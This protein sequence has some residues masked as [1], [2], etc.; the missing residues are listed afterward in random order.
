MMM[1]KILLF[2]ITQSFVRMLDFI[3]LINDFK[4]NHLFFVSLMS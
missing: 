1:I 2:F 4:L 3:F